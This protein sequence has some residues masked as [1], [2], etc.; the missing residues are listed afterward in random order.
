MLG[1]ADK[2]SHLANAHV[3]TYIHEAIMRRRIVVNLLA[4]IMPK[5][6][7][8][9]RE[10]GCCTMNKLRRPRYNFCEVSFNIV[11]RCAANFR[12]SLFATKLLPLLYCTYNGLK[13]N[14]REFAV[15]LKTNKAVY[16]IL[17]L[18]V[19]K[20]T[21]TFLDVCT[22]YISTALSTHREQGCN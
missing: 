12:A 22:L 3:Q 7:W 17:I 11:C 14:I 19:S 6:D 5:Y 10:T 1:G 9:P 15:R 13:D 21:C 4:L 18:T 20:C 2:I 8:F 16:D